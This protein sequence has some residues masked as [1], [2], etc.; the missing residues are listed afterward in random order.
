MPNWTAFRSGEATLAV[1]TSIIGKTLP[2]SGVF[3]QAFFPI[4]S[5]FESTPW[6]SY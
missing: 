6:R 3:G 1:T 5:S 4:S 2:Y